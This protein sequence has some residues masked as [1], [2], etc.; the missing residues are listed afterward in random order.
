MSFRSRS[1]PELPRWKRGLSQLHIWTCACIMCPGVSGSAVLL[2]VCFNRR[3]D[4]GAFPC[5]DV[6]F[7]LRR[8]IGFFMI[9]VYIPSILIV[10]L[11]WVSFWINIE[12]SPARVSIGLLTVLTTTTQSTVRGSLPKVSYVKAIDVWMSTC[13]LF[14]FA[15]L[16]EFAVVNVLLRQSE[17]MAKALPPPR[18]VHP[19][20]RIG[21]CCGAGGTDE[22]NCHLQMGVLEN[23]R[24]RRSTGKPVDPEG[25]IKARKI[26][27]LSRKIFPLAFLLFN[28]VY[29]IIYAVPD[30]L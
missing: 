26:D 18:P 20:R 2:P 5:K 7:V 25:K 16:L 13:L 17:K 28:I 12:A 14:V 10:I 22:E 11:S 23:G 15:S 8:D 4:A 29:W 21:N 1:L 24:E 6:R 19:R 27:K 9:Q 3:L 30:A